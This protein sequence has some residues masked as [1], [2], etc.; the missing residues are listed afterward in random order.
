MSW[1]HHGRLRIGAS[2]QAPTIYIFRLSVRV[3][4]R[5]RVRGL[6]RELQPYDGRQ[7]QWE[8]FVADFDG[9]DA[10]GVRLI[11]LESE[12]KNEV[13]HPILD[14]DLHIEDFDHLGQ[15]VGLDLDCG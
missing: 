11:A 12:V 13:L 9:L 15:G 6:G 14:L 8:H 1:D 2:T 10:L 7:L 4:V 5:V 3:R